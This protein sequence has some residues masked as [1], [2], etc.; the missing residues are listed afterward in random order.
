M[1]FKEKNYIALVNA[2]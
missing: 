2:N 1:N